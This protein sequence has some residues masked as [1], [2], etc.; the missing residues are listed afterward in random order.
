MPACPKGK[1]IRTV[2]VLQRTASL[3]LLEI[4]EGERRTRYF[5]TRIPSEVGP[6][7]RF[8]KF[9][10]HGGEVYD[11]C[12][13]TDPHEP[14]SCECKGHIRWGHRTVC[15]HLACVRALGIAG[16]LPS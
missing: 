6:A 4:R 3:L 1:P 7:Y 14:P 2:R 16:K 10:T 5:L 13:G 15:K 8:E 12:L 9:V 11:V